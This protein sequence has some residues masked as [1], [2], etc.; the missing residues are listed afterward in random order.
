MLGRGD[1]WRATMEAIQSYIFLLGVP[2]QRKQNSSN[3]SD[4]RSL[5]YTSSM[6]SSCVRAATAMVYPRRS[7]FQ[8]PGLFPATNNTAYPLRKIRRWAKFK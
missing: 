7:D 6:A 8:T 3:D 1:E 2:S 5:G 4:N